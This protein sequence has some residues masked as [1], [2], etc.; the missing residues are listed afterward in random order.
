LRHTRYTTQA[1]KGGGEKMGNKPVLLLNAFSLSMVNPPVLLRVEE[2][3]LEKVKTMVS[4]YGVDSA[5]GHEATAK[6]LS[7]L[8]GVDI[9]VNRKTVKLE[10][11]A[12]VFQLLQRLPEGKVLSDEEIKQIPYKFYHVSVTTPS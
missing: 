12:V 1:K 2:I 10:R 4:E 11:D 8:L 6:F 9:P 3:P 7:R 5:I